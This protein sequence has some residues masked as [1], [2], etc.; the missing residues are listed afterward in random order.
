MVERHWGATLIERRVGVDVA[1]NVN[2]EEAAE[3]SE[4]A[5]RRSVGAKLNDVAFGDGGVEEGAHNKRGGGRSGSGDGRCICHMVNSF[6]DVDD[7]EGVGGG[8]RSIGEAPTGEVAVEGRDDTTGAEVDLIG[9]HGEPGLAVA[10]RELKEGHSTATRPAEVGSTN[11]SGGLIAEEGR[12]L[13]GRGHGGD[14]VEVR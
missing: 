11:P 5:G 8:A 6:S 9:R 12:G 4:A 7:G 13:D 14:G 3:G 10:G 1:S 2:E